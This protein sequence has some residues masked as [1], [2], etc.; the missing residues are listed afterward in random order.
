MDG[1]TTLVTGFPEALTTPDSTFIPATTGVST[2]EN[3]GNYVLYPRLADVGGTIAVTFQGT[4]ERFNGFQI[5]EA[6]E[7]ASLGLL[8]A[9]GVML[10]RRRRGRTSFS[11]ERMMSRNTGIVAL[12]A[13]VSSSRRAWRMPPAA[14]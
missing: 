1:V 4:N 3:K 2:G 7:P 12:V 9:G 11:K 14:G 8:L 10:L 13:V 6:P 5:A